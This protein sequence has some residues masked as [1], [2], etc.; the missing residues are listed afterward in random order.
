MVSN[1]QRTFISEDLCSLI[2]KSLIFHKKS[3]LYMEIYRGNKKRKNYPYRI[4]ILHSKLI[5]EI[6][7][8]FTAIFIYIILH[9]VFARFF[10]EG[11]GNFSA[12]QIFQII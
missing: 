3:H 5:C 12:L 9:R 8:Q 1:V 11:G 4:E 6:C 10:G 7:I 2:A